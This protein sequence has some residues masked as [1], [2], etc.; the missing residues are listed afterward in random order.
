[1]AGRVVVVLLL[2]APAGRHRSWPRERCVHGGDDAVSVAADPRRNHRGDIRVLPLLP[3][4]PPLR[5]PR[6]PDGRQPR[7]LGAP[8]RGDPRRRY[9]DRARP[10]P[11]VHVGFARTRYEQRRRSLRPRH[12]RDAMTRIVSTLIILLGLALIAN[13]AFAAT[14]TVVLAV[15]GMT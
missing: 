11:G 12:G 4:A 8:H 2:L 7:H 14:S 10:L 1:M 15:E 9:I 13:V 3:R 6:V 5:G